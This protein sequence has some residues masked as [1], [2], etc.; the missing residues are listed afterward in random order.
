MGKD[1][2]NRWKQHLCHSA[3][4]FESVGGTNMQSSHY[5]ASK[6]DGPATRLSTT[7]TLAIG[8]A[9]LRSTTALPVRALLFNLFIHLPIY[10]LSDCY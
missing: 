6:E 4:W 9:T 10:L 2:C 5:W 8:P 3:R 7:S 1:G